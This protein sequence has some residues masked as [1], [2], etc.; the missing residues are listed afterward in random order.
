M[1]NT[2]VK[3]CGA[4]GPTHFSCFYCAISAP[5]PLQKI[6]VQIS[7]FVFVAMYLGMDNCN[8]MLGDPKKVSH[9]R[10]LR[11]KVQE[12][13]GLMNRIGHPPG[14]PSYKERG[15]GAMPCA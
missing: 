13:D 8:P 6:V 5:D 3:I 7:Y 11:D 4:S 12:I 2:N 15:D 1:R 14:S 9:Q 10:V